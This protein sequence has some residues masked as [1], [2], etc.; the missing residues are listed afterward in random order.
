ME[1][2]FGQNDTSG[3][4]N[5]LQKQLKEQKAKC[6][7]LQAEI[8]QQNSLVKHTCLIETK[9]ENELYKSELMRLRML[10]EKE[11]NNKIQSVQTL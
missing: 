5:M 2:K 3:H 4:V 7:A 6:S 1:Q 9:T 10:L 11:L 8:C